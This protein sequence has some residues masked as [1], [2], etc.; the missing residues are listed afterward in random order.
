MYL[1]P[2][3]VSP[4]NDGVVVRCSVHFKGSDPGIESMVGAPESVRKRGSNLSS[5]YLKMRA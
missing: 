1:K 5:V 2:Q 4:P 3:A